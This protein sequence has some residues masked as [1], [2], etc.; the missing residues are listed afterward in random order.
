MPNPLWENSGGTC[1]PDIFIRSLRIPWM[2]KLWQ[3]YGSWASSARGGVVGRLCW[4][5]GHVSSGWKINV[6]YLPKLGHYLSLTHLAGTN[7]YFKNAT[8]RKTYKHLLLPCFRWV[9]SPGPQGLHEVTWKVRQI[10]WKGVSPICQNWIE[11]SGGLLAI[12]HLRSQNKLEPE[13]AGDGVDPW[14]LPHH[15]VKQ[16]DYGHK[17]KIQKMDHQL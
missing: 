10:F 12:E 16:V 5:C 13:Y 14:R 17:L 11:R 8:F 2:W 7:M 1:E 4:V 6:C 15:R 9:V 3:I